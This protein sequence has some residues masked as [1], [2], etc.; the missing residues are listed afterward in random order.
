M[1]AGR[2]WARWWEANGDTHSNNFEGTPR[3]AVVLDKAMVALV[4]DLQTK[5]LLGQTLVVLDT[6]FVRTPRINGNDGRVTPIATTSRGLQG[7]QWSW[8]RR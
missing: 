6:E 5:G 7:T 3:H 1:P 4:A 8:T 2:G